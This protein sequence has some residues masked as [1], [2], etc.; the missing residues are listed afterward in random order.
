MELQWIAWIDAVSGTIFPQRTM[1]SLASTIWRNAASRHE[2]ILGTEGG[3]NYEG[4]AFAVSMTYQMQ[5][6]KMLDVY[7]LRAEAE[8]L[9]DDEYALGQQRI[10]ASWRCW[11]GLVPRPFLSLDM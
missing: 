10:S 2:Y 6:G 7:L 11:W 5:Y 9:K 3:L 8:G 4:L 1:S